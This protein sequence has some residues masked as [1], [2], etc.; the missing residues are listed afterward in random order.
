MFERSYRIDRLATAAVGVFLAVLAAEAVVGSVP[1]VRPVVAFL[2]VTLVPGALVLQVVG[3]VPEFRSRWLVYAVGVSLLVFMLLGLVLNLLLP[4]VGIDDPLALGPLLAGLL[5][6]LG[7][8]GALSHRRGYFFESERTLTVAVD[9]VGPTTLAF[10]LLP[11]LAVLAIDALNTTGS[12]LAIV[13]VLGAVALLPLLVVL[14][15]LEKRHL[16]LAVFAMSLSLVYHK[17]LWRAYVYSGHGSTVT[18]WKARRWTPE[19]E[20]LLPN[21]VLSPGFA[22]FTGVDILTQL[23]VVNPVVVALIPVVLYVSFGRYTTPRRAFLGACLFAFA[24]PFYFQYPP[25][26]RAAMPVLYLALLGA[27][28]GDDTL[29]AVA[30]KLLALLFSLGIV[31]SHYGTSYY[32]MFAVVGALV[33]LVAFRY[34]DAY[35]PTLSVGPPIRDGG[36]VRGEE[37]ATRADSGLDVIGWTFGQFY[38]VSVVAWYLYTGGGRR[39]ESL[40]EHVLETYRSLAAGGGTGSTAVR[41]AADYNATSIRLSKFVYLFIGLLMG[42]GLLSVYYRRFL[43]PGVAEVDD[44]YLALASMLLVLFGGTFVVSGAWGGGRPMMVVFS[45]AGV[46]AVI[47]ADTL[48]SVLGRAIDRVAD[49]TVTD[50]TVGLAPV[51]FAAL[52]SAF[53][54]L[55]SGVVAAVAVGGAA[56]SNVPSQP[57]FDESS[58]PDI[59]SR[60]YVDS[61]ISTHVWLA[62]HRVEAPIYGDRVARGQ[63]TDKYVGEIVARTDATPYRFRKKNHPRAL[64]R[65]GVED[66]YLLM[67]GHTVEHDTVSASFVFWEP[68]SS[69]EMELPERNRVYSNDHAA[70]YFHPNETDTG[71][72]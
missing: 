55:N 35:L 34:L 44:Q 48:W 47:G 22:R 14:D 2:L 65:P 57:S 26:G 38:V 52:L 70:V 8:L 62:E 59:Q 9:E 13:A 37:A 71:G 42:V 4:L 56:P 6:V 64:E 45:V 17:S 1:L 18:I 3:V 49:R 36:V 58:N 11:P 67:L 46:F 41:L 53:L 23:K 40:L 31:V 69:Y 16:P 66:G 15:R 63:A 39:L 10:L 12:N 20:S 54:L 33:L 32:V 5:L 7:V 27:V 30:R 72:T 19:I 43:R 24:H 29:P 60:L 61:D 68:L 51:S 25:A 21:A 50:R 28:I